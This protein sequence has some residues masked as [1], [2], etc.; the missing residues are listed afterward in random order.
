VR[1]AVIQHER[2]TGLGR[3]HDLLGERV[4]EYTILSSASAFDLAGF[5]G[6]LVLGG[7]LSADDARLAATR[8]SIREAVLDGLPYLGVCLG[9]QLL[10]SA[11]GTRVKRAGAEAGIHNVFLT[12][13]ARFDPVFGGLPGKIE[14]FGWHTDSFDLPRSAVPLAGSLACAFQ[15]FRYGQTAYGLQF[16]PEVLVDDV[17]AWRNVGPYQL[18]LE[19]SERTWA[20]VLTELARAEEGLDALAAHLLDRWLSLITG[21]GQPAQTTR[22]RGRE[23]AAH[24]R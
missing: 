2:A 12:D 14:V 6:L 23:P 7:S 10:A 1:L 5:D 3:F 19:Q 11:L 15:A 22:V 21:S 13:A 24:R 18:L 8:D 20:S 4:V 9:G 16:H 17:L